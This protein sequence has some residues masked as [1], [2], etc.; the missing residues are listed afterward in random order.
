MRLV[1]GMVVI[2]GLSA[3]IAGCGGGKKSAAKE[4]ASTPVTTQTAAKTTTAPTPTETT[5]TAAAKASPNS[6][7]RPDTNGDGSPDVQTFRG[8]VGDTFTLVGQPGYKRPSKE[9]VRVT[10]LGITGPFNGYNLDTGRQLIGIKVRFQRLGS[11][12][13]DE[14]QPHGQLT[15]TRGGTGKHTAPI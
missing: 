6:I 12:L 2:A 13:F 14:P 5:T 4:A 3:S 11:K 8:K 7:N 10:V 1:T 15:G 9:A